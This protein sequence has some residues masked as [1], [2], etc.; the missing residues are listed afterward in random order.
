VLGTRARFFLPAYVA[1]KGMG[2]RG[3]LPGAKVD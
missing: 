2:R 1:V 3:D